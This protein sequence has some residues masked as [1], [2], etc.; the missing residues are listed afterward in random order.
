MLHCN[1][2]SGNGSNQLPS[3]KADYAEGFYLMDYAYNEF[4]MA[5]TGIPRAE[6]VLYSDAPVNNVHLFSL[7]LR[8]MD[9]DTGEAVF[10]ATLEH[11]QHQVDPAHPLSVIAVIYGTMPNLAVGYQ[12]ESGEYHFAFVEISGMDGSV[13]LQEF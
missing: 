9:S 12:D 13:I 8:S 5:D 1:L 4:V 6:F 10:D 11:I 7:S 3:L 2:F